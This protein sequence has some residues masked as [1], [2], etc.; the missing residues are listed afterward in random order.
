MQ[1]ESVKIRKKMRF[2][3]IMHKIKQQ[4]RFFYTKKQW[5]CE[6]GIEFTKNGS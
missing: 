3:C 4:F 1:Y 6:F 2:Y 5:C